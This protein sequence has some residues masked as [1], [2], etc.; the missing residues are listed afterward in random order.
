MMGVSE[1]QTR[2]PSQSGA[3]SAS[4]EAAPMPRVLVLLA[5][6]NGAPWIREQIDSILAQENVDLALAI[7]D[8]GSTDLTLRELDGFAANRRVSIV[9]HPAP[10][11]SAAG[12]FLALIREN[13]AAGMDFVAFADQ[14]DLWDRDKLC[15]ACSRIRAQRTAG[16]SSATVAAW[17]NGTHKILGLAGAP[18][19]SDYLFEGAGQGCTFVLTSDLYERVRRLFMQHNDLTRSLHYHDW[20]VYALARAWG[21]RWSFDPQPSMRYRQHTG[22]DTGARGTVGGVRKRFGLIRRG[23]YRR[24]L[25]AIAELCF[26]AAPANAT[27]AA[28]RGILLQPETWR[29]KLRIAS[30]CWRGGR[31]RLRDNAMVILAALAG[32]I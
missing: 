25:V 26:A 10:T 7:R 17:E 2:L 30:F 4:A 8:D 3:I 1:A 9:P 24:Q 16:Y 11:G 5:A 6:F 12:N 23:W 28:W 13:P 22:N 19:S 14:D 31:R 15:R 20:A 18:T 32:W 29:R 21:L 27:V